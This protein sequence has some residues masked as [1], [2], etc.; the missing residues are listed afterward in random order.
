MLCHN[1]WLVKTAI[2]GNIQPIQLT[3]YRKSDI[4]TLEKVQKKVTKI[5]PKIIHLS[6]SEHLRVCNLPALHY[7]RI[8]GDMIETYKI[9][10]GKYD[11]GSSTKFNYINHTN[12]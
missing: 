12:N 5:L 9:L 7:R 8:R 4:E 3:P 2:Q 6:Y 10:S 11:K 1:F